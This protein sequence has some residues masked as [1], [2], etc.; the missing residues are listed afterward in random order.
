MTTLSESTSQLSLCH[1][2]ATVALYLS[3]SPPV[4]YHTPIS[5]FLSDWHLHWNN[6]HEGKDFIICCSLLL[7]QWAQV[8]KQLYPAYVCTSMY[9]WRLKEW[10]WDYLSFIEHLLCAKYWTYI[11]SNNSHNNLEGRYFLVVFEEQK[12]LR[13]KVFNHQ[14]AQGHTASKWPGLDAY[15]ALFESTSHILYTCYDIFDIL[16]SVFLLMSPRLSSVCISWTLVLTRQ[17][18]EAAWRQRFSYF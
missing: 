11:I 10:G 2:S 12:K 18:A 8:S 7:V 3:V 17:K 9:V 6:L 16:A 1:S 4:P 15:T 13:L 5:Y 14:T